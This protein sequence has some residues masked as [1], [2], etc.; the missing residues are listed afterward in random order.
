M[1]QQNKL[2]SKSTKSG[3]V[4]GHVDLLADNIIWGGMAQV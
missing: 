3:I 4:K 1:E 2:D